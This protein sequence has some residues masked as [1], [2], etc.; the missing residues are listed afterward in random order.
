[1][2]A[3]TALHVPAFRHLAAAYT[4]NELGNWIGDVALAILVFDHTGSAVATAALFLALRFAPALLA[5]PL[6]TRLEIV[7]P[8]QVLPALYL[9]EGAIFCAIIVVAANFSLPAVLVL[10]A[11]DGV[12]AVAAR[13][14]IRSVNATVLRP[15]GLLREGNAIINLGVTGG[16]ALGPAIAGILV[17]TAGAG[18][19]LAVDAA[20]FAACAAIIWTAKGLRMESDLTAGTFGRL[21]TGLREAWGRPQ[22]RRLLIAAAAALLFGAAVIPIEVIF[23][24]RTLHSGDTGYGLLMTAW[25]AGM[26]AGGAA[27]AG[28]SRLRITFV[29]SAGIT[30]IGTGYAG[31]AASPDLAVACAFSGIGGAGNGLWSIAVLTALQQAIPDRNQ[32]AVMALLESIN[33]AMPGLGF[34][35]GGLVTAA[36]S[37]RVAY[38]VAAGGIVIVLLLQTMWPAPELEETR[39]GS[40]TPERPWARNTQRRSD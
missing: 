36:A 40:L 35:L 33:Q 8:R 37:T 30:L 13:A 5:P 28:A 7:A 10:A 9:A 29:I 14:L 17:A 2:Q 1:M 12:L 4:V 31:L 16:G 3:L 25:G 20:T 23:A 24:K 19:A 27:F 26:L 15:A 22:V 18:S 6:T 38:A 21:R 39:S 32:G 11:M 34:V